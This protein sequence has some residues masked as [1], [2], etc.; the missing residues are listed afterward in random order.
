MNG[1]ERQQATRYPLTEGS[2]A[3]SRRRGRGDS[4]GGSGY[5][6]GSVDK[7]GKSL[8]LHLP[9]GQHLLVDIKDVDPSFL[10]SEEQLARTMIKIVDE[11][12]I[13]LLSYHC[14]TLEH[15][16][17]SCAGGILESHVAFHT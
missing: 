7:Y 9:A 13:T 10:D 2:C 14:H 15:V 11:L 6:V 16:G 1:K 5:N 8:D 17:V 4:E 3:T 12:K